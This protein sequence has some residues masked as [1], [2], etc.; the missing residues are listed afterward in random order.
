ME[1]D[2]EF[3]GPE[4]A[5]SWRGV[6]RGELTRQ[7]EPA[8]RPATIADRYPYGAYAMASSHAQLPVALPYV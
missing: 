7:A 3:E 8:I 5:L 1:V 2:I 6:C 4:L